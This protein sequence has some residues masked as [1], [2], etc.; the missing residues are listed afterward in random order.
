[1]AENF[2][3]YEEAE[4]DLLSCATF[5]AGDIKSSEGYAE[6]VKAVVPR[7]LERGEVDL[8]AGLADTVDDPFVRDRLLMLVAEKCAADDDDDYAFQLAEAIED[9][10][11]QEAAR[12]RIALQK[13]FKTQF[14]KALE[15]AASLEHRSNAYALIAAQFAAQNREPE[16]EQTIEK[17]DFP[18]SKVSALQN[19]ALINIQKGDAEKAVELLSK[20]AAAADEIEHSEEKIRALLDIGNH[21]TEAGRND[22]AVETLDIARAKAE[23]LDNVH[24]D[25]F[26]ANIAFGFLKAGS[27]E[28]ADRT[29]DLVADKTQIS[30]SL[31]GF[32]REFWAKNERDE[33]LEALEE[34]YAILKSQ[35]EKET[36]DSR[37]RYAL[38]STIAVLFAKFERAERALETAQENEDENEQMAALAQIAQVFALGGKDDLARQAIRAIREDSNRM[39]A[40]IGLSD[41][42]NRQNERQKAVE[43]LN[44]AEQLAETVPQFASRS[45]AYAELAKRFI[46]YGE[47]E[48]ARELITENLTTI[49]EIRDESS[50]VVAL[51]NLSD[52]LNNA[53][54]ILNENDRQILKTMI[55]QR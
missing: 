35:T 24:R 31:A 27:L 44:E 40:L 9:Y 54:L 49:T 23:N 16:A 3:S 13:A 26:L 41:A 37:A 22:K 36:R 32:A 11:M 47:T 30:N 29:L 50:R 5:L 1:M 12:E 45:S 38:F 15:I 4:N 25:A 34:S 33:A 51:A 21:F 53:G 43:F 8:A 14:E 6:A 52:L 42:E 7:Y 48:K 2:I 55:R 18:N 28:L 10:G 20:A 17:I 19:I 39:F 46:D